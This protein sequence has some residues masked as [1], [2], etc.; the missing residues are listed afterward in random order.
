MNGRN[1]ISSGVVKYPV[2]S[3]NTIDRGART[4]LFG[5]ILLTDFAPTE[6]GYIVSGDV[7]KSFT[8]KLYVSVFVA[9]TLT[10]VF[11]VVGNIESINGTLH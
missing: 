2:E 9:Q 11:Q 8:T 6:M 7:V 3:V 1:G 5:I 4:F 10:L